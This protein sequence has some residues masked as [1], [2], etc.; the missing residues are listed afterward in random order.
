MDCGVVHVEEFGADVQ[1]ASLCRLEL[2]RF[3]TVA[4]LWPECETW[5]QGIG[6]TNRMQATIAN[7][8]RNPSD[9]N[10]QQVVR[11]GNNIASLS[12]WSLR[13]HAPSPATSVV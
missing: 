2:V 10:L 6:A 12:V 8:L 11:A 4:L 13:P 5:S 1:F 9:P 7:V 3:G